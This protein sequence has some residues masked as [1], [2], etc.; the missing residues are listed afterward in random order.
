LFFS[1]K[2]QYSHLFANWEV[3]YTE[4]QIDD[5]MWK[6]CGDIYCYQPIH[7]LKKP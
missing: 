5:E 1:I 2:L 7:I 4:A 3:V 6:A